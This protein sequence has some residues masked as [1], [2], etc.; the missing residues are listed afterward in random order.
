VFGATLAAVAGAAT[1]VFVESTTY[2]S[3]A[4]VL[5]FTVRIPI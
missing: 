1:G 2:E 4:P 3:I 5:A